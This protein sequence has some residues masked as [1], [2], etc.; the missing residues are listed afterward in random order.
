MDD[1][2]LFW[3]RWLQVCSVLVFLFGSAFM[4]LAGAVQVLFETLYFEPVT[5]ATLDADAAAYSAFMQGVM[6][7][8]MVGWSVLL[9]YVSRGGFRRGE[10][11]AWKMLA[12]SLGVWFVV[13]TLFSLWSGYW[14]NAILNTTLL[15]LFGIP[16]VATY[17]TFHTGEDPART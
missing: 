17:G 16:L 3:S 4:V 12:V 15:I 13:D 8:V 7:A 1:R 9:F 6:G 14:Q 11:E 5:E 2:L 10:P